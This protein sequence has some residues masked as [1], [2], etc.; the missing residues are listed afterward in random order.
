VTVSGA[1]GSQPFTITGAPTLTAIS[2]G[3]ATA[4]TAAFTLTATGANFTAAEAIAWNGTALTT[5]FVSATQLTATVPASLVASAGTANIT[6]SSATGSQTF[7]ITAAIPVPLITAGGVVP[8]GSTNPTVSAGSWISIYGTNFTTGATYQWAG[9]YPTTLGGVSVTIDGL[10]AYLS[11]VGPGQIN[12]Q[13]PDDSKQGSVAVIVKTLTGNATSTV[14]LATIA[15]SW[16]PLYPTSYAVSV[17]PTSGANYTV[18]TKAQPI[19]PGTVI[20]LFGVGFGPTQIAAPAGKALSSGPDPTSNQ[21]TVTVG[22]IAAKVNFAGLILSGLFQVNIVIPQV[23]AGD[24]PLV[25]TI[26]GVQTPA[27]VYL[28]IGN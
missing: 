8:I 15:P 14:T 13:V 18:G 24:Q 20:E 19:A 11:Y 28:P 27:G 26:N 7:T 1:A 6:V 16:I 22:G 2:P 25:A 9:D 4:G 21:V 10:A 23:A 5:N 12:A 3:S 17:I